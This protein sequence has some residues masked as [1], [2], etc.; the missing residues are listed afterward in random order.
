MNPLRSRGSKGPRPARPRA[1]VAAVAIA[2]ALATAGC[3][4]RAATKIEAGES[5]S[6]GEAAYDDFFTAV[7]KA[8]DEAKKAEEEE[9]AARQELARA[10][11][12]DADAMIDKA[13]ERAK[14]LHD[15]GVLMHLQLLPSTRL[16]VKKSGD[17]PEGGDAES[18]TRSVETAAGKSMALA[19]RVAEIGAQTA[20]LD[21]QRVELREGTAQKL[22]GAPSGK[23]AEIEKELDGSK[24]VLEE[25]SGTSVRVAG[26]ASRLLVDLARAVETG[27]TDAEGP[28]PTEACPP[29]S[30]KNA[31]KGAASLPRGR[32]PKP[33][34]SQP[35]ASA[36]AP[37]AS[38]APAAKPARKGKPS[39]DFEP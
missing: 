38:P 18:L 27:A 15:Y 26:A 5:P 37:A 9:S 13:A 33:P 30:A 28:P 17:A 4:G 22:E 7:L 23:R 32:A 6:T 10:L 25:T 39:D 20:K 19:R 3:F 8:R 2:I 31:K 12:A 1:P 36:P 16:L 24:A 35:R 21:K 34:A 29:P 14:K 11:G